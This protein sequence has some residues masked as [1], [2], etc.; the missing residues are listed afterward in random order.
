[1]SFFGLGEIEFDKN[2]GL[3]DSPLGILH[4]TNFQLNTLRYPLDIGSLDKSHYIVFYIKN[5]TKSVSS[6]VVSQANSIINSS[7]PDGSLKNAAVKYGSNAATNII[8]GAISGIS[9]EI[10]N[11]Y[12]NVKDIFNSMTGNSKAA[13]EIINSSIKQVTGAS[14]NLLKNTHTSDAIALYMPDTVMYNHKQYYDDLSL[15][16]DLSGRALAALRSMADAHR[17]AGG[18]D[19]GTEAASA[20]FVKSAVMEATNLMGQASDT[21]RLGTA[22]ILG[23]VANP[24]LEMIYKSPD[25]RT[26]QFEFMFYPRDQKEA[27]E[28]QEI[29]QKF[30]YH[31]APGL[32]QE[33][34]GFLMPPS[35]FDIRM[36]CN[37]T[38]NPNIPTIA[39]CVLEDIAVDYA[40]NGFAAYEIPNVLS[41]S[42]GGTGM[43]VAIRMYL[44]FTEITY[45]TKS[46]FER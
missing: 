40:P 8:N 36:Y 7:V 26:F 35:Q 31:Q 33:A 30:Y 44:Q 42:I 17:M 32:V 22:A 4:R 24:L 5:H 10:K 1:M 25:F 19:K 9:N 18:G 3:L 27:Q 14:F 28:V 15:G 6:S 45:L 13:Q 11:V 21:A 2:I 37:G 39:T 34:Q 12:S 41:P 46:D 43:P 29:I 20:S 23:A 38:D 16:G